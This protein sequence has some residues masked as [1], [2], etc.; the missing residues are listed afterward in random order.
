MRCCEYL[1]ACLDGR[2]GLVVVEDGHWL[3][4]STLELIGDLLGAA[5][6][7]LLVR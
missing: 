5:D 3:D 4:P 6:G 7:R 2:S 1:F